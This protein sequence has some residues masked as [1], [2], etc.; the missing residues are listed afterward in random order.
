[1]KDNIRTPI[2]RGQAIQRAR[3]DRRLKAT[4]AAARSGHARNV[5]YRLERGEGITVASLFGS[6][7]HEDQQ[8]ADC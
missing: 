4:D 7:V 1:M 5:L 6:R 2:K 3:N 8:G